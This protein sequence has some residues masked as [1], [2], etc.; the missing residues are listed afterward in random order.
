[1]LT[2]TIMYDCIEYLLRDKTDEEALECLCRLLRT[3]GKELD[4]KA[5]EKVRAAAVRIP[6]HSRMF[7]L[8]PANK[9]NLERHYRELE[10]IVREQKTSARI[11]FMIQDL[12][13]LR[14]VRPSASP[15][16]RRC[17]LRV[18]SGELG[19]TPSRSEAHHHRRNPR[20]GAHQARAARAR[21]GT[22]ATTAT[23]SKS[24]Y[25]DWQRVQWKQSAT[26]QRCAR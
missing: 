20:A 8:Q 13:E 15:F 9:T 6:L 25:C 2:D 4:S 14:Q 21:A 12:I 19:R 16:V 23:R 5:S 26:V 1:M 24:R 3:I 10:S 22:R 17:T 18:L 7:S 11:R